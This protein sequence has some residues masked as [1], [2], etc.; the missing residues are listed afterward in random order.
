MRMRNTDEEGES[1]VRMLMA[2]T[3]HRPACCTATAFKSF[4]QIPDGTLAYSQAH[5]CMKT[6]PGRRLRTST[7]SFVSNLEWGSPDLIFNNHGKMM[8]KCRSTQMSV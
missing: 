8:A 6:L 7:G 2:G 5:G 1:A 4:S 3:A